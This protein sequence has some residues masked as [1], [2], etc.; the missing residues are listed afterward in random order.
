MLRGDARHY[1]DKQA[2]LELTFFSM[3]QQEHA[4]SGDAQLSMTGLA[5]TRVAPL[6]SLRP[7]GDITAEFPSMPTSSPRCKSLRRYFGATHVPG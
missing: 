1:L 2:G 3:R 5:M 6:A 7:R 4:A